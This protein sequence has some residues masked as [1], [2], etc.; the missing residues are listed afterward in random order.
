M[1]GPNTLGRFSY[2][3]SF[4]HRC[5][6]S[7]KLYDRLTGL[8]KDKFNLN[9][10]DIV[11]VPGS[12]TF[13]VEA[14]MRSSINKIN[15]IGNDGKFKNR[16]GDLSRHIFLE[17]LHT[18]NSQEMFCQLETSNSSVYYKEGCIVDAI[19]SFP[20]YE[21]PDGTKAFVC[22]SNKQLGA[23]PGV[24]IVFVRKDCW[25]LFA[26]DNLFSI[27]NLSLYRKYSQQSQLPTTAPI[28]LFQQLIEKVES[29]DIDLLRSKVN[30]N[31][32]KITS[33]FDDSDI[34]G[35]KICPVITVK[36]EAVP[37]NIVND[38]KIYHYNNDYPY[39][40]FFTYST[41][42]VVYD[43]FLKEVRKCQ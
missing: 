14:L 6:N 21:I 43:N 23:F 32:N 13:G 24:S 33:L 18:R 42:D 36:K 9:N 19:S 17:N 35:E 38:F 20:F 5:Q 27:M 30:L 22:C 40:Q 34:I 11:F 3:M 41:E 26:D 10:Y 8:I 7:K 29:F 12:G 1:F 39:Y 28:Q 15:V 2:D 4:S 25:D 37:S 31:S 16:W